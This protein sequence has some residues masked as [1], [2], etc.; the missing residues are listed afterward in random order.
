MNAPQPHLAVTETPWL[1][2]RSVTVALDSG[3]F[4][5]TAHPAT[6]FTGPI[7]YGWQV[8]RQYGQKA[9]SLGVGRLADSPLA[10]TRR[11]FVCGYSHLWESFYISSA[12]GAAYTFKHFGVPWV[13]LLGRA[14]RP[15]VVILRFDGDQPNVTVEPLSD[16]EALWREGYHRTSD[17]ARLRGALAVQQAVIDRFGGNF[18]AKKV[19]AMAV[20]PAAAVTWEGTI[21]SNPVEKGAITWVTEFCGRGGMGSTLLRDFNVAALLFGGDWEPGTKESTKEYDP[22]FTARFGDRYIRVEQRTTQKYSLDPKTGTGGTFGSNYA[23]MGDKILSFHYQSVFAPREE[24][25][26][27]LETFVLGHYWKQFQEETIA[28]KQFEHCGEPCSVSCKKMNGPYKKDYEPYH[29]LGPLIGIF[30]QRAAERVNEYADAMG[31]DAIQLGGMLGWLFEAVAQ[32]DFDPADLGLPPAA[33][34]RFR[35]FTADPAAFDV[36]ADSA[37]NADYALRAI[38][39]ILW[40]ER[41]SPLREGIRVAAQALNARYPATRP[42]DRA[43]YLAH[44]ERGGLVP[45]QYFVP[46]MFSPMP[47]MGKYYVFYG[48]DLLSPESLGQWNVARMAGELLSDNAGLCRFHRAWGEPMAA[49]L[50]TQHRE[51]P[52][53]YPER[54]VRL[55]QEIFA[56]EEP[57]SRFWETPR[58][59]D[60]FAHY[61]RWQRENGVDLAPVA[62]FFAP[63]ALPGETTEKTI[64]RLLAAND[65]ATWERLA[66]RYWETV[67]AA[68]RKAVSEL[69]LR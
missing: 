30:D 52:D 22:D 1:P 21:V 58:L 55:T 29:A 36:V 41:A 25:I 4:S 32:G 15:S 10:G 54:I 48:H 35:G 69:R 28:P 59:I 39:A 44:G 42:G 53:D 56:A 49:Q 26:K 14:P 9:F 50:L 31:F 66:R 34:L 40:D 2:P 24:R 3:D 16:L 18:P 62:D 6:Q 57:A 33:E 38:D 12:G 7:E 61:W 43:V 60:L 5:L 51:L 37:A 19:R 45:N 46:G 27:Q 13:T 23:A 63:E 8:Y 17:G 47:L 11:L 67:R 20:G 65:R 68:Q 64:D